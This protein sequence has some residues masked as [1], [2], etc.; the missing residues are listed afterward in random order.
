MKDLSDYSEFCNILELVFVSSQGQVGIERG[1]SF[2]ENL[3]K[4]NMEVCTITSQHKIK[5]YI[6][7]NEMKLNIY[8]IPLKMLEFVQL[9]QQEY[10]VYLQEN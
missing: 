5:D 10:E 2:H 7:C 3:Q 1:F 4:Q 8:T 9:S 6:L